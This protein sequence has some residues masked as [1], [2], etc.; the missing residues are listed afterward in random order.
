MLLPLLL[1]A[2]IYINFLMSLIAMQQVFSS[3][4]GAPTNNIILAPKSINLKADDL[5]D[6]NEFKLYSK[7]YI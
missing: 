5:K 3:R 7:Q 4:L 1:L 2:L 6:F